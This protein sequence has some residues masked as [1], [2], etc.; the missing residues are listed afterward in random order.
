MREPTIFDIPFQTA[1]FLCEQSSET[2]PEEELVVVPYHL[3]SFG[4]ESGVANISF[5]SAEIESSTILHIVPARKMDDA[6]TL[7]KATFASMR[8]ASLDERRDFGFI[9]FG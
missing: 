4:T 8:L 2:T 7:G 9:D 6:W 1:Q 3:N 5:A